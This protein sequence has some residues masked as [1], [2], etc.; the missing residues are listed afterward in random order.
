M[1]NV[2]HGTWRRGEFLLLRRKRPAI[3]KF[4]RQLCQPGRV[5]DTLP[6]SGQCAEV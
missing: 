2:T 4:E 3:V 1:R 6:A 5:A